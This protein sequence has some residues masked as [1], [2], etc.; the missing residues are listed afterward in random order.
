MCASLLI[1]YRSGVCDYTRLYKCDIIQYRTM[2]LF[3][4]KCTPP[5]HGLRGDM[6]WVSLYAGGYTVMMSCLKEQIE[7]S[8]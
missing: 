8:I 6:G 1:L 7:T 2:R 4:Y 5:I 3:I